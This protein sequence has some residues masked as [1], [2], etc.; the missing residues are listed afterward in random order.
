[1]ATTT[2]SSII[3]PIPFATSA[4]DSSAKQRRSVVKRRTFQRKIYGFVL[5]KDELEEWG[6]QQFG[7]TDDEEVLEEYLGKT[8]SRLFRGCYRLWRRTTMRFVACHK[9]GPHR[10]ETDFCLSL[11]DN[12]SQDTAT[13][14]SREIIDMMKKNLH[15]EK[16]PK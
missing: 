2:V 10:H 3:T 14:P 4:A 11:A 15:I 16:D 1:M 13:P 6:R 9:T 5:F 7:H 8:I 12:I